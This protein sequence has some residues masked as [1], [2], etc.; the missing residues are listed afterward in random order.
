MSS[1]ASTTASAISPATRRSIL[2]LSFACFASMAAQRICD[3]MLPE[4]SRVFSVGLAQAAQV[5][6]VFAIA[7]GAA[8]L[9]YGPLGD[10]VGKFRVITF[11]TLA[12]S[13]GSAL[14][15]AAGTLDM[16]VFAR[17]LMALGA[18]ALIPL[19]MAWVG[20]SVPSDQLQEM[21]TRTGLGST[22]GIV[23]GQLVGGLLTDALGWRWAFV[24]MT[25]LF[26]VVGSLLWLNL[27]QQ[28]T[29]AA[30]V[31]A[32]VGATAVRP[33]FVTQALLILTGSWSRIILL[34][35]LVEGAAGFG[36]LAIWASH[37]HRSLGLS[38]S[39]AGA[40]VALFGLG[41]MLYMAVGRHLIR[42]FGQQ[43]LV[44]FGGAIL[45]VC[46]L[47]LAYT[48]HWGP[49]LPASLLAGF[50]FF[51]FH[52]TMQTNATQMAPHARGTA[53]SLFSSSL[54]LGQSI[55]VVLAASL[56]DRVGTSAVIAAGGAVMA[57]E[58]VYFAWVLRRRERMMKD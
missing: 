40:I 43:G 44:L 25:V 30:K 18:A 13:I 20:D 32:P 38:L 24:F 26:G 47:V 31:E 58:G 53:V 37:L 19:S 15:V 16:L 6:S 36:V 11:A 50:G 21:L 4:L 5:V 52:N 54:F 55:G 8:Q 35:A 49:A 33:G 28:R 3:A 14:A 23:G 39:L 41:G 1:S 12:C 22:L 9:F 48:P 10:R 29:P 17:L 7:Y 42:R 46:A 34:M 57:L 45:G 27:R 56:I 51:M 2:L